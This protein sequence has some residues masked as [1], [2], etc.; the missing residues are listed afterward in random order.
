M[1]P[2]PIQ[3]QAHEHDRYEREGIMAILKFEG[4]GIVDKRR[5]SI[6]GCTQLRACPGGSYWV[7]EDLCSK[8]LPPPM[9][10]GHPGPLNH[11]FIA[12]KV[13]K[14]ILQEAFANKNKQAIRDDVE[15]QTL[16]DKIHQ[17]YSYIKK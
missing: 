17:K 11:H 1:A 16:L 2:V 12:E 4:I 6:C 15:K 8:C 10:S 7:T 5:C 14:E 9:T 13:R 3:H